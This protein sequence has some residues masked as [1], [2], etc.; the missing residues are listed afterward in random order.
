MD[1]KYRA[2]PM[3][4]EDSHYSRPTAFYKDNKKP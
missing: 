4:I 1:Y 2:A 3:A